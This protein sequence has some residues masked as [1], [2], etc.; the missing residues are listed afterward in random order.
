[1]TVTGSGAGRVT[2]ASLLPMDQSTDTNAAIW[3]SEEGVQYWTA[4]SDFQM[5]AFMSVD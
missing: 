5:A 2:A 1:M 4:S 3:K